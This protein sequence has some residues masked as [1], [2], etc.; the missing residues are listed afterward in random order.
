MQ[1]LRNIADDTQLAVMDKFLKAKDVPAPWARVEAWATF[2]PNNCDE[3]FMSDDSGGIKA[4]LKMMGGALIGT[5]DLM[6]KRGLLKPESAIPDVGFVLGQLDKLAKTWPGSSGEPELAWADAAICKAMKKG[7]VFKNAPYGIEETVEGLRGDP[8]DSDSE[9]DEEGAEIRY[10][11]FKWNKE[12]RYEATTFNYV[13]DVFS[14][15]PLSAI[16]AKAASSVGTTTISQRKRK[17]ARRARKGEAEAEASLSHWVR[18]K[19]L[20]TSCDEPTMCLSTWDAHQQKTYRISGG[21][22]SPIFIFT[23]DDLIA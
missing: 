7:V 10:R 14:L 3:W 6:E 12:V 5:L 17:Q 11:E 15:R 23:A 18:A 21:G 16:T 2:V 8:E 9:I 20:T 19:M 22:L 1:I 4:T 13:A